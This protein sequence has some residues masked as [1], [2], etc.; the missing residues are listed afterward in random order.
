[1]SSL[2]P[3][4]SI[5]NRTRVRIP[6]D[7]QL[8]MNR[9]VIMPVEVG[10]SMAFSQGSLH[11]LALIMGEAT[12]VAEKWYRNEVGW[13]SH[14]LK[15]TRSG[16]STSF[17]LF[18]P[19]AQDML[20]TAHASLRYHGGE[21]GLNQQVHLV[22]SANGVYFIYP[23]NGV[24]SWMKRSSE[25]AKEMYSGVLEKLWTQAV[26]SD[27]WEVVP[28]S[29]RKSYIPTIFRVSSSVV[30]VSYISGWKPIT[31]KG[32]DIISNLPGASFPTSIQGAIFDPSVFRFFENSG[33]PSFEVPLG[34]KLMRS[35]RAALA[36]VEAG[37]SVTLYIFVPGRDIISKTIQVTSG[38][39]L[40]YKVP[41]E[42]EQ[43]FINRV[44]GFGVKNVDD[45][46]SKLS[47]AYPGLR[48]SVSGIKDMARPD[49][50]SNVVYRV[51]KMWSTGI[52]PTTDEPTWNLMIPED[53]LD[54]ESPAHLML[55]A[56]AMRLGFILDFQPY[57]PDMTMLVRPVARK[58]LVLG[59]NRKGVRYV[60]SPHG[61]ILSSPVQDYPVR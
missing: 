10:G 43:E 25:T 32:Q 11:S 2:N 52:V 54:P 9:F 20:N 44:R 1:M 7:W 56:T 40:V 31:T 37:T 4:F 58:K 19:S 55:K 30:V 6:R 57:G 35:H 14:P 60:R 15:Y 49:S 45:L 39:L 47:R 50:R 42:I 16:N 29:G 22:V 38:L 48:Y 17:V 18:P 26:M 53:A 24:R 59:E 8:L 12:S 3:E 5:K 36:P 61:F 51:P 27:V 28:D 13:H 23:S 41:R 33:E 46:V 21:Q 34:A